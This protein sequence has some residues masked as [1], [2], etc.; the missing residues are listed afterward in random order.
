MA[1]Q[2]YQAEA[3]SILTP[4]CG[5]IAQAVFT[6]S[7]SHVRNGTFACTYCYVTT[8]GVYGGLQPDD[9]EQC[10]A[11]TTFKANAAQLLGRSLRLRIAISS[12]I[13]TR[14]AACRIIEKQGYA[15]WHE[16]AFQRQILETMRIEAQR[17]G[18]GF[19]TGPRAFGWL[20]EV[21]NE[22]RGR[23]NQP[24]WRSSGELGN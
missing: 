10:G 2:Y 17:A 3:R 23:G 1:F 14:E 15:A 4:T 13:T 9:W 12:P 8:M 21:N 20:A 16:P 19:S 22:D 11:F 24:D 7:L 18:R 5:F 6:H